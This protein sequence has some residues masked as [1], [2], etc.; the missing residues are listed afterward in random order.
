MCLNYK[1]CVS[2]TK[3][4]L[5]QLQNI[6]CLNN[7]T[8][9]ISITKHNNVSQL[10]NEQLNSISSDHCWLSESHGI[11][12]RTIWTKYEVFLNDK[13]DGIYRYLFALQSYTEFFYLYG[14]VTH[15]PND[16]TGTEQNKTKLARRYES[17]DVAPCA[18]CVTLI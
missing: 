10:Q 17:V 12:K 11:H 3:Y 8:Q 13:A 5:S 6:T 4:K 14:G 9:C 15:P 7:E 1:I 18:A 16:R 2:V